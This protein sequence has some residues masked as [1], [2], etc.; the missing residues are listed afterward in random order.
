MILLTR[1]NRSLDLCDVAGEV[2]NVNGVVNKG[3]SLPSPPAGAM[4]GRG[5]TPALRP[6]DG[7]TLVPPPLPKYLLGWTQLFALGRGGEGEAAS[8]FCF[9]ASN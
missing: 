3:A 9:L 7:L 6:A 5:N 8:A 2:R 4:G 1:S